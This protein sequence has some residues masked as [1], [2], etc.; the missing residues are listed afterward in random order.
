M[1]E[2]TCELMHMILQRSNSSPKDNGRG[3]RLSKATNKPT[4]TTN[5]LGVIV[6]H[7]LTFGI[8]VAAAA[9]KAK[10][11]VGF[12]ARTTRKR[13][14]S[15]G[16][17]HQLVTTIA[18]P[19]MTWGAG[20]WWNGG[21]HIINQLSP[22]YH[23]LARLI[24]GLSKWTPIAIVLN[25]AGMSP[26]PLFLDKHSQKY[27]IRIH[28]SPHNHPCKETLLQH[29][30]TLQKRENLT[31]LRRIAHLLATIFEA[32]DMEDRTISEKETLPAQTIANTSKEIER[33]SHR[34][35]SEQLPP[36]VTLLYTDGSKSDQG[37]T[38]SAWHR[39]D[40]DTKQNPL[41]RKMQHWRQSGH[42]RRKN[43]RTSRRSRG[44]KRIDNQP[45]PDLPVCR[46]PERVTITVRWTNQRMRIHEEKPGGNRDLA[47]QR[48]QYLWEV[49]PVPSEHNGKR[50]S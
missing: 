31:G 43:P 18:L 44:I 36:G 19:G 15:P 14:A 13:G 1:S 29:L 48:L 4:D 45:G 49:D 47:A 28:L 34:A 23:T 39:P 38:A 6:Y 37:I 33:A 25:Q 24:T 32:G 10:K 50:Q 16:A 9:T 40:R 41:R 3:I 46:Q 30:R 2:A 27:C 11:S 5:S 12:I 7:R 22:T 35:W 17:I 21:P 42:R 20:I 8:H 26:L